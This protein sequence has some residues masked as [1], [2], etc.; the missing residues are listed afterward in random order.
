MEKGDKEKRSTML[1]QLL[2][3][4]LYIMIFVP[5]WTG[6]FQLCCGNVNMIMLFP[7]TG[8]Y[9][10]LSEHD[11]CIYKGYKFLCPTYKQIQA[12]HSD[13]LVTVRCKWGCTQTFTYDLFVVY[14]TTLLSVTKTI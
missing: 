1:L 10:N 4:I 14:L 6:T 7:P 11:A 3:L 8:T 13:T 12:F 9:I 5:I 2:L